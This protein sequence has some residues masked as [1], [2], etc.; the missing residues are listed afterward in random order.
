MF[1][2]FGI[3]KDAKGSTNY[4]LNFLEFCQRT[5]GMFGS[6]KAMQLISQSEW[7][8]GPDPMQH[9]VFTSVGF[10]LAVPYATFHALL[11]NEVDL[12]LQP[13]T[14]DLK[15]EIVGFDD[16]LG[17]G[18]FHFTN[19]KTTQVFVE[20]PLQ[21]KATARAAMLKARLETFGAVDTS[22]FRNF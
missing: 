4:L 5:V 15:V 18:L 2:I 9:G 1:K 13:S 6:D 3:T 20:N 19:K 11:D 14:T 10:R 17:F 12:S 16:F 7:A 8:A 21:G 22:E